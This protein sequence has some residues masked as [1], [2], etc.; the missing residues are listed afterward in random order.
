MINSTDLVLIGNLK[1]ALDF[2]DDDD[3]LIVENL[4][5]KYLSKVNL[6]IIEYDSIS[7]LTKVQVKGMVNTI[8]KIWREAMEYANILLR[9]EEDDEFYAN[10][11]GAYEK[12]SIGH[13]IVN[14]TLQFERQRF[15]VF[16]NSKTELKADA[17]GI[18][19]F[20]VLQ[21]Y[22]ETILEYEQDEKNEPHT[23][24]TQLRADGI[25]VY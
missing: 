20:Y 9:K 25:I 14:L 7:S 19:D 4:I 15:Y 10:T 2:I 11:R 12:G 22:V 21:S 24:L 8:E 5:R 17:L 3:K 16:H 13:K 23:L 18:F 6:P 1:K